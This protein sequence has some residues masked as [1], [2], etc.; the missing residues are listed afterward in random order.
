MTGK[1]KFKNP[2]NEAIPSA[3]SG[4]SSVD[5]ISF[6]KMHHLI[7]HAEIL[8]HCW[9]NTMTYKGYSAKI[10]YSQVDHCFMGHLVSIQDIIGFHAD[11]VAELRK[12]FEE[13]VDDYITYCAGQGF[14]TF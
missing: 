5:A 6:E 4:L 12:S 1:S 3:A 8:N 14:E 10:E 2:A 13:S 11:N 7:P 9:E